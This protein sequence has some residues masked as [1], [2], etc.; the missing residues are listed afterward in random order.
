MKLDKQ[1]IIIIALLSVVFILANSIFIDKWLEIKQEENT[2]LYEKGYEQGLT[3]AVTAL[4]YNTDDCSVTTITIKNE[5]RPI[6]DFSCFDPN[7][8]NVTP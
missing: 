4:F 2:L 7:Q 8:N 5:T 6:V 3:D 1:K